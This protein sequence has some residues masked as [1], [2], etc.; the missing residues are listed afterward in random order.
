MS[1]TPAFCQLCDGSTT[2]RWKCIECD[3]LIC[4]SC[5]TVHMKIKGSRTHKIIDIKNIGTQSFE[6]DF[7]NLE[8]KEHLLNY[9]L[10]CLSCDCIVCPTCVSTGHKRHHLIEIEEAHKTTINKLKK[11]KS[12]IEKQIGD[13]NLI[14]RDLTELRRTESMKLKLREQEIH[15]HGEYLKAR[16]NKDIS[17]LTTDLR[18]SGQS[19]LQTIDFDL[20]NIGDFETDATNMISKLEELITVKDPLNFFRRFHHISRSKNPSLQFF[21][22][23]KRYNVIPKFATGNVSV[24]KLEKE[25]PV[26]LYSEVVDIS[27]IK[28]F[29]TNM[30]AINSILP[31]KDDSVLLGFDKGRVVQQVRP[32]GEVL[33]VLS[34]GKTSVRCLA[35]TRT[36]D[37]LLSVGQNEIKKYC[38]DTGRFDST[39]LN[40]SPLIT[41]GVHATQDGHVLVGSLNAD[42]P[43]PG[44]R[45]LIIFNEEGD[46]EDTIQYNIQGAPLFNE[47]DE[48][49]TT[50]N[51][52]ILVVDF[53]PERVVA[54][55]SNGDVINIYEGH[56]EVNKE[57]TFYSGSILTSPHDNVIV[58]DIDTHTI[59]VLNSEG[60]GIAYVRINTI[61]IRYP[62]TMAFDGSKHLF[63]GC[64]KNDENENEGAN[65]YKTS[66]LGC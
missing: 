32:T 30:K 48:I 53:S 29:Q 6:A 12:N 31:L 21:E 62:F 44:D 27:V 37:I 34:T 16:I 66:L 9:C 56:P 60:Y 46:R 55:K 13:A 19:V 28:H 36:D 5:K 40:V 33:E 8:C 39:A 41:A 26:W 52:N 50:L 45:C 17:K 22:P 61:G 2:L 3:V 49:T 1:Q 54:L 10:F 23:S 24:G 58:A 15:D 20:R 11:R 25:K 4:D 14:I 7:L 47:P 57:V 64:F 51:G 43:K 38:P 42:F 59:H 18:Q 63:I 65:L 35:M